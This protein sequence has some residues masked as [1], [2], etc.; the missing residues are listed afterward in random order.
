[1]SKG[2]EVHGMGFSEY[3]GN[4]MIDRNYGASILH[5]SIREALLSPSIY[6]LFV[7]RKKGY[8][9]GDPQLV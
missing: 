9:Y 5:L 6:S 1:V 8:A 3:P 4:Q 2:G 7:F